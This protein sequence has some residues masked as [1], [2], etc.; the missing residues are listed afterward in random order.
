MEPN[1]Y[2][3]P[4]IREK[5]EKISKKRKKNRLLFNSTTT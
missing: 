1:M 2:G 3:D 4:K 5:S